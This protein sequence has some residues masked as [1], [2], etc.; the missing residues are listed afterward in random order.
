M[1]INAAY[2]FQ[3]KLSPNKLTSVLALEPGLAPWGQDSD[4]IFLLLP[5]LG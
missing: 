5:A 3:I 1:S 2:T 4:E